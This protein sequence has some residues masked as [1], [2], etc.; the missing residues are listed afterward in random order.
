MPM[1]AFIGVRI[2]WLMLAR[3]ALFARLASSASSLARASSVVALAHGLGHGVEADGEVVDLPDAGP[4]GADVEVAGGDALG[5]LVEGGDG[6]EDGPPGADRN[7]HHAEE[8]HHRGR[9]RGQRVAAGGGAGVGRLLAGAGVDKLEHPPDGL[10]NLGLGPVVALAV[11]EVDGPLAGRLFVGR[12]LPP[13]RVA[14]ASVSNPA[15]PS[16]R[17]RASWSRASSSVLKPVSAARVS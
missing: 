2:S 12:A 11:E 7:H 10:Q 14:K 16:D 1:M 17:S 6:A 4:G 9:H 3:K 8:E 5:G 13:S 15:S